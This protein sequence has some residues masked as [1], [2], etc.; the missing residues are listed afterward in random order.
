MA[1]QRNTNPTPT[2]SQASG[3][4][5]D[6]TIL[7]RRVLEELRQYSD[8]THD[9][10][11]ELVTLFLADS[12]MQLLAL[13]QAL[14]EANWKEVEKRSH[15]LKGSAGSIGAERLREICQEIENYARRGPLP[16]PEQTATA[17]SHEMEALKIELDRL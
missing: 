14:R 10:V 1:D 17:V 11:Q 2:S 12:P 3:G 15:R 16:T 6:I 9:L 5:A 13:Q 4:R 8:D 7:D